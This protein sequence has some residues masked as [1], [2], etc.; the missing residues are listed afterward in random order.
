M[1]WLLIS[2][3]GA[4]LG[5]GWEDDFRFQPP[6]ARPHLEVCYSD[7][8]RETF[9][10]RAADYTL[11]GQ[12]RAP[13]HLVDRASGQA[14][15]TLAVTDA[16]GVHY[17][18]LRTEP[19]SRI[20]LYRRGPYFCEIH[21]LDLQVSDAAGRAAP[22]RGDLALYCYP[23]KLLA[24]ITW[25]ATADFTAREVSYRGLHGERSF[26]P[27]P[28]VAGSHQVFSFP[29]FQEPPALPDSAWTTTEADQPMRYDAVRGCYTIGSQNPGGFEGHCFDHPNYREQVTFTVRNDDVPRKVYICHETSSGVRGQVEGGVV[30]DADGHPLP[31]TVDRK[32]VV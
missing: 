23:D 15:L 32:S 14:W 31:L 7:A 26:T 8:T 21:W 10:I 18:T 13:H 16:D 4:T 2:V 28:F 29:V 1:F 24:S 20:N 11:L 17:D 19:A 5:A 25:H 27:E 12:L 22:L 30:L 6:G 9:E 3:T